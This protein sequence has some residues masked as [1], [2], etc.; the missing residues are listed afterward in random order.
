MADSFRALCSDYY[1]NHKLSVKLELPRTRETVL[2]LFERVR[3]RF[4]GMGLFRRYRDELALETGPSQSPQRWLAVRDTSVRS[5]VVNPERWADGYALHRHVLEV[6]PYFL[7]ISPLDVEYVE[8]L[9][10]F[11]LECA[12]NHDAAIYHALLEGSPI[13]EILDIPD[14]T[15][16]DC[17]PLLAVAIGDEAQTEVQLEV[18]SRSSGEPGREGA[19][20]PEAPDPISIYLTLRRLGPFGNITEL[21]ESLD[22]LAEHG[23]RLVDQ[24]VVEKIILPLRDAIGFERP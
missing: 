22:A 21:P 23:E 17:Q 8:L 13:G 18:K 12:G 16:V 19:T 2:E 14:A 1:V 7:S 15:P 10:G 4:P 24:R 3:K 20:P 11:D 9:Y 6:V 5:G